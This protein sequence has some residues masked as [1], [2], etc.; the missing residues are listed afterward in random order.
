MNL[1]IFQKNNGR[2]HYGI[3]INILDD[4]ILVIKFKLQLQTPVQTFW[5]GMKYLI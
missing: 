2:R 5:K 3:L 1:V 4:N